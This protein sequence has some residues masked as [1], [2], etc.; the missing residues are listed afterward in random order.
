MCSVA[1]SFCSLWHTKEN[2]GATACVMHHL[3]VE[4]R[5]RVVAGV[6][7]HGMVVRAG[8]A[9]QGVL[10]MGLTADFSYIRMS[11]GVLLISLRTQLARASLGPTRTVPLQTHTPRLPDTRHRPCRRGLRLA[12][13]GSLHFS[14]PHPL[15]IKPTVLQSV[16]GERDP[17]TTGSPPV[18]HCPDASSTWPTS[19]PFGCSR[20]ALW[21]QRQL[22][23]PCGGRPRGPSYDV[24]DTPAHWPKPTRAQSI[25]LQ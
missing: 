15:T 25:P 2:T 10:G 13:M 20:G 24:L 17:A 9:L 11:P 18:W 12:E 6:A 23:W 4:R 1:I 8:M 16:F 3:S 21:P 22:W 5:K 7:F 14:D 19:T